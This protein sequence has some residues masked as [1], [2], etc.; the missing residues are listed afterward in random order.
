[1][2][3]LIISTILLGSA[4]STFADFPT[5]EGLTSHLFTNAAIVWQAPTDHLPQNFWIYQREL[6]RIFSETVISN[7][8][9]LGS[10]QSK[11]F[12]RL[13][14]NQT[15]IEV[16]PP[17]PCVNICNFFIE[18][19]D[20]SISFQSPDDKNRSPDKI[21]SDTTTAAWAWKYAHQLG[22]DTNKLALK[23]FYTH[24]SNIDQ[25]QDTETN[26]VCGRGI[27][28]SR[29]LDGISFFTDETGDGGEGF[30]IEF[31]GHGVIRSFSLYWSNVRR[32]ENIPTFGPQEI[33]HNIQMHKILVLPD[34]DEEGY[35]TR[36]QK[37]ASVRRVIVTKIT[38]YYFEGV[39]GEVPTN[40]A[41]AKL[42]TPVA[43]LDA[44]ADIGNSNEVVHILTPIIRQ[45]PSI[46]VP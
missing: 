24:F 37:L 14:T 39:F 15:C 19:N 1:M 33:V 29:Q 18:P 43:E 35:F 9:V 25:S 6:P 28:L 36:L 23:N 8:I 11:G 45:T 41:P 46:F 10:L 16:E 21:P 3:S 42:I 13:S 40:N 22:L 44:I 30:S 12:P 26:P 5:V 17:N 31:G 20:A 38:P 7:A 32:Y 4:F 34:A 2:K 27:F